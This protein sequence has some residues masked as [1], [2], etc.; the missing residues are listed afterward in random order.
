[1]ISFSNSFYDFLIFN[2]NYMRK[3]AI[4]LGITSS[5]LLF[6]Q[7]RTDVVDVVVDGKIETQKD[8]E[9]QNYMLNYLRNFLYSEYKKENGFY[10]VVE[11]KTLNNQNSL[12]IDDLPFL[13]SLDIKDIILKDNGKNYPTVIFKFK[14]K[15][16]KKLRK[17][18]SNNI[19]NGI[20][21]IIDK[22]IITMPM[23]SEKI[24]TGQLEYNSM[25]PYNET[26]K[27]TNKLKK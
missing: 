8:K 27:L 2:H 22:K 21:L 7:N 5:Y 18:T 10:L 23:I 1:M 15:G 12:K 13:S 9:L 17:I 3:I 26:E 6:S 25:I 11:Q 16:V 4:I 24:S 19:G 20:A 14:D